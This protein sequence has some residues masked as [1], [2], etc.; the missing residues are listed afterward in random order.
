[1]SK[2]HHSPSSPGRKSALEPHNCLNQKK[3][4]TRAR[5]SPGSGRSSSEW[6]GQETQQAGGTPPYLTSGSGKPPESLPTPSKEEGK[7]QQAPQPGPRSLSPPAR[8]VTLARFSQPRWRQRVCRDG[9]CPPPTPHPL[10]LSGADTLV[11][12]LREQGVGRW[13]HMR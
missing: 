5:G 8:G 12:E 1:M 4:K 6:R 11:P 2:T 10:E 9:L 7:A 13:K 3:K